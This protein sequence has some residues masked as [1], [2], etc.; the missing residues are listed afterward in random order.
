[1]QGI[2]SREVQSDPIRSIEEL[3]LILDDRRLLLELEQWPKDTSYT[4]LKADG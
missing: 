3:S 2:G 1:M 4:R